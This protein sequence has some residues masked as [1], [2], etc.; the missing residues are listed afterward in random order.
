MTPVSMANSL[1]IAGL[2]ERINIFTLQIWIAVLSL[3]VFTADTESLEK[4]CTGGMPL[5]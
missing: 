3:R 1:P 4:R 5:I 2:L